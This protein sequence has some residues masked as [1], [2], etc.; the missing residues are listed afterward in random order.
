MFGLPQYN[1]EL[2][3]ASEVEEMWDP[4]ASSLVTAG[5]WVSFAS[6]APS[7]PP[8]THFPRKNSFIRLADVGAL[9][10]GLL[11]ILSII[12]LLLFISY[13]CY[14]PIAAAVSPTVNVLHSHVPT[15]T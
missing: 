7:P 3:N 11:R 4:G 8:Q 14:H 9:H 1:I 2:I 6:S 13:L 5:G 10:L 12:I 15:V